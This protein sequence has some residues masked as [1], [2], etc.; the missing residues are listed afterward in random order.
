VRRRQRGI[1]LIEL[2]VV[3]A[4]VG[5]LIV[6]AVA[7]RRKEVDARDTAQQVARLI[8]EAARKAIGGGAVRADVVAGIV[9]DPPGSDPQ[10]RAR[11]RIFFDPTEETQAVVLERLEEEPLPSSGASWVEIDRVFID[12]TISIVGFSDSTQLTEGTAPD[13]ALGTA[14]EAAINCLPDGQC[15]AMTLYF[16]SN[17]MAGRRARLAVMPLAGI[18]IT[19]DNW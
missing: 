16:E 3:L 5:I 18:P 17:R 19:F 12:R 11:A 13:T 14:G 4:I 8:S 10:T 15:S 6:A 7:Y 9:P 2:M 1:T